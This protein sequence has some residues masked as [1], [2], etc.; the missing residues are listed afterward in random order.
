MP[1]EWTVL[2]SDQAHEVAMFH[3]WQVSGMSRLAKIVKVAQFF[4]CS[5]RE[6][7]HI[8]SISLW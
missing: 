4:R 2:V 1:A 5:V 6:Y 8:A 3:L 7:Q